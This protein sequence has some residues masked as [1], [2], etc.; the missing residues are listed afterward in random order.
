[1]D[2]LVATVKT[3]AKGKAG[4]PAAGKPP[5]PARSAVEIF[6][7]ENYMRL[8]EANMDKGTEE[9]KEML[10]AEYEVRA[11]Q[12]YVPH[13]CAMHRTPCI[14]HA[15][16]AM[17]TPW[18]CHAHG[19]RHARGPWPPRARCPCRRRRARRAW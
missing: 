11:R 1:M 7:K 13:A 5:K 17:H 12:A 15:S 18:P 14:R 19:M 10:N 9:I 8:A 2:V 6:R 4:R 3:I 16:H